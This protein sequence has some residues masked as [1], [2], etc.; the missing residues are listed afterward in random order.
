[1]V[2][3]YGTNFDI[4]FLRTRAMIHG[5][6]FPPYGDVYTWD[7]YY[8]VKSKMALTR[9]NLDRA[10]AVLGI[11][12]K[13][14]LDLQVWGLAA[15]GDETALKKVLTHNK[16]DVIILEKLHERLCFSRKWTKTS[17]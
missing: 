11:K 17:I 9:N 10:C 2:T 16:Y 8:T 7:L 13:T 6:E 12:G 3:Y 14:H 4:P 15:L 1:V 5:I